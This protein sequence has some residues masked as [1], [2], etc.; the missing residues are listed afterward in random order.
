MVDGGALLC[1]RPT[2]V[3]QCPHTPRSTPRSPNPRIQRPTPNPP[4]QPNKS[5]DAEDFYKLN[6]LALL[7]QI[8]L[9]DVAARGGGEPLRHRQYLTKVGD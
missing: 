9:G 1:V 5:T 3:T 2:S 7:A 4:N 8:A 6:D